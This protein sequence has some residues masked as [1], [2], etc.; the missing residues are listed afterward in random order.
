MSSTC[1]T[2]SSPRVWGQEAIVL[3][4]Q[5]QARII[6]TRVGTRISAYV[7]IFKSVYHPH[8]CGDKNLL[9]FMANIRQ[10][11]SPRVWGQVFLSTS[12]TQKIR[13][14]PTRVGTRWEH[15]T[16][17]TCPWDHP[18]ACGDKY[19]GE[20]RNWWAEGSSPRVWGQEMITV[21]V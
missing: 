9:A 10:G 20:F 17:Y 3:R 13:I 8:A 2:R 18:H 1:C 16:R 21:S 11:S 15:L 19:R 4:Q 6:P 5:T 12:L 14:I 7:V